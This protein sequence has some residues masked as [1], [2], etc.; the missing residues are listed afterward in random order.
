MTSGS[1]LVARVVD[2]YKINIPVLY[3][4]YIFLLM[5]KTAK[6][7]VKIRFTH[8]SFKCTNLTGETQDGANGNINWL[9][10]VESLIEL[11]NDRKIE[12]LTIIWLSCKTIETTSSFNIRS[13]WFFLA[14]CKS[15][16]RMLSK[17]THYYPGRMQQPWTEGSVK[18][19][20][21]DH[22]GLGI[23]VGTCCV[24]TNWGPII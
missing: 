7:M 3:K 22:F 17:I 10:K 9:M 14:V 16:F 8:F 4:I 18:V 20:P 21:A 15:L 13:T 23:P 19:K 2:V 1:N 11:W 5:Y 24:K 12:N 6:N